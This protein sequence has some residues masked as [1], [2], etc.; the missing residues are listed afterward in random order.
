MSHSTVTDPLLYCYPHPPGP[1]Y[2]RI[3]HV[4]G[5]ETAGEGRV[6]LRESCLGN[7]TVSDLGGP[8]TCVP[9][10]TRRKDGWTHG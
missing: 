3:R 2:G 4:A 8:S 5:M 1:A 9:E 7:L 10:G 6:Y